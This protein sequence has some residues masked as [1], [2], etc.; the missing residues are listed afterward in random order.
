MHYLT[1]NVLDRRGGG[2]VLSVSN[3]ETCA[4]V[5]SFSKLFQLFCSFFFFEYHG[6]KITT[7]HTFKGGCILGDTLRVEFL[8]RAALNP[9]VFND[10]H[11]KNAPFQG[12]YPTLPFNPEVNA[13]VHCSSLKA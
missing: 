10:A 13:T 11:F 12:R 5:V 2:G 4:R 1:K 7:T 8:K 6:E 3:T 9:S